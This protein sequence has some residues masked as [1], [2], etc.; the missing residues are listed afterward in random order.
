MSQLDSSSEE[1]LQEF[2]PPPNL[3]PN[4]SSRQR[5]LTEKYKESIENVNEE[6]KFDPASE[7]L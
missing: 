3:L 1:E 4:R 2:D 7:K 5:E 6:L